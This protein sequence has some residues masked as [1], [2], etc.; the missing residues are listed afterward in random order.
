MRKIKEQFIWNK[1]TTMKR[2]KLA[3]IPAR[4]A[5]GEHDLELVVPNWG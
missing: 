4:I 1:I 3:C 2:D 5:D